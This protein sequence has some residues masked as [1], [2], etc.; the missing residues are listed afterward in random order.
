MEFSVAML[1]VLWFEAI[2]YPW[3]IYDVYLEHLASLKSRIQH[4]WLGNVKRSSRNDI[5][6]GRGLKVSWTVLRTNIVSWT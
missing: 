1:L 5:T 4:T 6:S 3:I 2:E